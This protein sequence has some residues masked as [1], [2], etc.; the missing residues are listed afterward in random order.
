M[1]TLISYK[2]NNGTSGRCDSKCYNAEHPEC[3]CIC[4]GKNHGVG[5][6]RAVDNTK[7][8]ADEWITKPDFKD[9][10]VKESF[11]KEIIE[12]RK[13]LELFPKAGRSC[14]V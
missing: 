7:K 8:M 14:V 3:V 10:D 4:G 13:Q 6:Q 12:K 1:S 9:V 11:I 2:N 5:F